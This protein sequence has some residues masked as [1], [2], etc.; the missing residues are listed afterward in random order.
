MENLNLILFICLAIPLSMT[1]FLFKGSSRAVFSF[2]IIGMF[3]ALI[4]GEINTL[5]KVISVIDPQLL[6]INVAPLVEETAKAIP[7]IFIAFLIRPSRQKL[8]EFALA[9]GVGFALLE[10]I[11]VLMNSQDFSIGYAILRAIGA[12]M[13]HGVCTLS[14][15]F[16]MKSVIDKKRAFVA[17]TLSAISVAVISHSIYN[18]LIASRYMIVGLFLPMFT[19]IFIMIANRVQGKDLMKHLLNKEK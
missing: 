5:A 11:C 17:G 19:F 10:N 4:S 13:M 15:G 12:G 8:V 1:L 2:L 7:I 14:I 16:A 18:M 9:T 3:T 6:S